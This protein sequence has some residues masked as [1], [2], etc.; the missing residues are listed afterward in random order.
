MRKIKFRGKN[1][2]SGKMIFGDFLDDGKEVFIR[3][4]NA[5]NKPFVQ[6]E[7]DSVT[8]LVGYDSD[9]KEVYEGDELIAENGL[10][11]VASIGTFARIEPAN[12]TAFSKMAKENHWKLKVN[13]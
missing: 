8:Q 4:I 12:D 11:I 6:I 3:D 10:V 2:W 9:G 7:S 5:E 13:D 1:I